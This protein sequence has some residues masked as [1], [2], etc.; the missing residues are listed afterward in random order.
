[1]IHQLGELWSYGCI[2]HF[3]QCC[4]LQKGEHARNYLGRP[5]KAA[6]KPC[7]F[8]DLDIPETTDLRAV[9]VQVLVPYLDIKTKGSQ[10]RPA[11]CYIETEAEV[12]LKI[13]A[14]LSALGLLHN[15]VLF[16]EPM[17]MSCRFLA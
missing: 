14:C 9:V 7:A 2:F 10:A 6:E 16:F 4:S 12:C 13:E 5:T 17:A 1:M 11:C 3:A 15:T 8:Y